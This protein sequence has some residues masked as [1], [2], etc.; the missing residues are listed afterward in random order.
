MPPELIKKK[1]TRTK[2]SLQTELSDVIANCGR[3]DLN[4]FIPAVKSCLSGLFGGNIGNFMDR[5]DWAK[6]F[7]EVFS[8]ESI[9]T[10]R[11]DALYNAFVQFTTNR[12]RLRDYLN[13]V[14]QNRDD[15]HQSDVEPITTWQE[16]AGRKMLYHTPSLIVP[17]LQANDK[18]DVDQSVLKLAVL[19]D[20]HWVFPPDML[21]LAEEDK[22]RVKDIL[23][24]DGSL[25]ETAVRKGSIKVIRNLIRLLKSANIDQSGRG[26]MLYK[27]IELGK[28]SIVRLLINEYPKLIEEMLG[29][30]SIFQALKSKRIRSQEEREILEEFLVS[31]IVR[32]SNPALVKKLL[33]DPDGMFPRVMCMNQLTQRKGRCKES[34]SQVNLKQNSF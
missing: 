15:T 1:P 9:D 23:R 31:K 4:A 34:C 22:I 12:E 11:K 18:I 28:A 24:N 2:S 25:L 16:V 14:I 17:E 27:A 5:M 33:Y 30:L 20:A 32:R 6:R 10:I 29:D 21:N 8:N 19:N 13:F 7:N 26:P 3:H